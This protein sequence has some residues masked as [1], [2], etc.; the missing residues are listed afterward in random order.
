MGDYVHECNRRLKH[1][2]ARLSI[3]SW[4]HLAMR[5][6]FGWAGYV[7]RLGKLDPWR[8][9]YRVMIFK[10][11]EWLDVVEAANNGRQLHGRRLRVWR[12]GL[13][14]VKWSKKCQVKDWKILAEDRRAW[15]SVLDE[16]AR[17][18]RGNR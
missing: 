14:L 9:T 4:D 17:W 5:N 16:M 13:V 12:W 2:K 1:I 15:L 18:H 3:S 6:H 8:L 7:A 11:R 10:N